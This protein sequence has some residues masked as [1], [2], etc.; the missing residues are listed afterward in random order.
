MNP[1]IR[2]S[3]LVDSPER[4][5]P[6]GTPDDIVDE[7]FRATQ[8]K[9]RG[10]GKVWINQIFCCS[11]EE[12][13]VNT[14]NTLWRSN[15]NVKIGR[16]YRVNN[17]TNTG[18]MNCFPCKCQGCP[19]EYRVFLSERVDKNS[20]SEETQLGHT[21]LILTPGRIE[22]K[23]SKIY[24]YI[25]FQI[26]LTTYCICTTVPGCPSTDERIHRDS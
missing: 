21:H 22:T 8:F 4:G 3:V 1:L 17:D 23:V 24:L 12:A 13:S 19:K 7:G 15:N 5:S 25:F 11:H 26:Y 16:R 20:Y 9:K 6:P 10:H 2:L 14:S 18:Q